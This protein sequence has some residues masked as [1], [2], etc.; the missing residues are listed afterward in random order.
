MLA[1]A[2]L[3]LLFVPLVA[4]AGFAVVAQRHL[5]ALGMLGSLGATDSHTAWCSSGITAA[6]LGLLGATSHRPPAAG[7]KPPEHR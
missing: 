7:L 2:A 1:L 5:R 3:G 4:V 6:T